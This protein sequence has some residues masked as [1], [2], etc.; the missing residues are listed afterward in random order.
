MNISN[1]KEKKMKIMNYELKKTKNGYRYSGSLDLEGC[2]GLT[3]LPENLSVGGSLNLEG[4][5][6]LTSLPENLSVGGYL[7][8]EGC[9]G[10]IDYPV[11]HNCGNEKRIIYIKKKNP[12]LIHIGC[13]VGTQKEAINA[14]KLKYGNDSNGYVAKIKKCFKIAESKWGGK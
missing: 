8:L 10:L 3:S 13:F 14:V 7:N 5:T 2:T 9:T 1:L 11:I 6:G 12:K 4:C